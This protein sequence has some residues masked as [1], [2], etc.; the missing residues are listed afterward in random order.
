MNRRRSILFVVFLFLALPL[1]AFQPSSTSP[2]TFSGTFFCSSCETF[3]HEKVGDG[4]HHDSGCNQSG[5]PL[6]YCDCPIGY[7]PS[8]MLQQPIL[9]V[10]DDHT[11]ELEY[12]A[13][14][15]Y[16]NPPA[17]GGDI[18]EPNAIPFFINV[19]EIDPITLATNSTPKHVV[20]PYW[21]HGKVQMTD[22]N[23]GCKMY[24]AVYLVM[25]TFS[26]IYAVSSDVVGGNG[27]SS[28]SAIPDMGPCPTCSGGSGPSGGA[29]PGVGGPI[30]VGSGNMYY[31]EP[32]FRVDEP[33]SSLDF[34]I[35]YNSLETNAGAL[36]PGFT[37]SF[38]TSMKSTTGS[39]A[40]RVWRRPDGTRVLFARENHPPIGE[41][42][43]PIYP[44]DA[45]GYVIHDSSAGRYK[46]TEL[47]GTVTEVDDGSAGL[48][49]KTTDRWG[50]TLTGSYT[51]SNLTTITDTLG[52]T[53][54]LGYSGSLLTSITDG[55][56]N[57]WRFSYDGSS[58]LEKIFDPLHTS[59]T[60]WQQFTW[61]TY[62]TGKSAVA[63]VADD[64]GAVLEG[65]QYDTS[66]RAASSWSGDTTSGSAPS[67]GTNARDLVTLSYDSLTQTTV[68]TKID[69]SLTQDSVFTL[70]V[71]H[72]RFL[73]T[74][75]VGSC[76]SCGAT[77]DAQAFTFDDDNHV[78]TKTVGLDKTGSGGTDERV[79]SSFTYDANGNVLTAT[80]AVGKTEEHT[81]T[82][83]YGQANWPS[84]VT[85]ITETSVAKSG[86]SRTTT[87]AWNSGETQ[88][89]TT[90]SGYLH[91][92]DS[93]AT[94]YV[95]TSIFDSKHRLT[96]VD[97]PRTNQKTT[98][99]YYS[100]TDTTLNRRGRLHE[101][102]SYSTTSAFLTTSFDNYDVY[103]TAAKVTDPNS[104]DT[105]RTFDAR[106]RT[107]T[108][109]S[110]KPSS[111]SNEPADYDTTK[112]FDS[113]DRL[114]SKT[115][116]LGNIVRYV[117]EDGTNRL[118]QT[119]RADSSGN[120][121]ERLLLTLN[122]IGRKT[123]EAAQQC[124]SPANPCSSWTTKRSDAFAYDAAGRLA[125]VTHPDSTSVAHTYDSRGNLVSARDERHTAAN[126]LFGFDFRD[127]L[128][129]TTQKRTIVSGTD[130]VTTY[131]YDDQN[132]LVKVTDPKAND[133]TFAFDDFGRMQ[134]QASPVS[135]TA[136]Y[137]Y[138]EAG[139]LTSTTDAN[140]AT[141]ARTFDLLNR[142]LTA[143]STRSSYA[144]E[145]ITWTYDDA[146]AGN[147][148]LGRVAT[149]DDPS[150]TT[151]YDYERRGLVR[152]EYNDTTPIGTT[153]TYDAEGNGTTLGI[154]QYTFDFAGRPI[155]AFSD[156]DDGSVTF[157]DS[158]KYLPFGPMT[159]LTYGNGAVKTFD[160]DSRYRPSENKLT[161]SS[162]VIADYVYDNDE[163]GNITEI[164]DAVSSG[165]NRD[166][167]YDDLN[168]LITA[169]TGTSL[170]G[171][172]SYSYDVA[173]NMTALTLG[174]SRSASF[175]YSG[176]TS[177]LSSVNSAS[178]SYDSAGNEDS[179]TM[180]ARNLVAFGE[181]HYVYDGR[182]VR[183]FEY[184]GPTETSLPYN[185]S[186]TYSNDLKLLSYVRN[187]P[188]K[189]YATS[190]IWLNNIPVAQWGDEGWFP[191]TILRY[192]FTDHLGTPILQM[193]DNDVVWQAEYEPF[194]S[195]FAM[196]AGGDEQILRFPGQELAYGDTQRTYNIFRWYRSDWSRYT[197]SD[198]LDSRIPGLTNG[199]RYALNNPQRWVDPTGLESTHTSDILTCIS[200]PANCVTNYKCKE[201][202]IRVS[203][204][205]F[206]YD[207]DGSP[208]N[209]YKHCY[210]NCCMAKQAGAAAAKDMSGAH[211]NYAGN[212]PCSREMDEWNNDMGSMVTGGDS[213]D[214]HCSNAPLQKASRCDCKYSPWGQGNWTP[215]RP[216]A[217][218]NCAW[219]NGH[220]V[221][222]GTGI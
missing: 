95:T 33:V 89:T 102:K 9:R 185:R 211:E 201:E 118:L 6:Y 54:T 206:G 81:T 46:W 122:T 120:E 209:A 90:R 158:V 83:A 183:V 43:R 130:V 68:T 169:N 41:Y 124:P 91:S 50:N 21:E 10:I 84:F 53:W 47:D 24:R 156:G 97:G 170:W 1:L 101:M 94:S 129:T 157:V 174:S 28:C 113:R 5:S 88:L 146:T 199:Y 93:S 73:A 11:V 74:S 134:S 142:A 82:Y 110:V 203:T 135:G 187:I 57:Q 131:V 214:Q 153:Y 171:S 103:G 208:Q 204:Q 20:P 119:I 133:T 141:T 56:S 77:E 36:G 155:S 2:Y 175:S 121:H 193:V 80:Q 202:A 15:A 22:M 198:P 85:S 69:T 55:A 205:K 44:G 181:A 100:D 138:D 127:R 132:N 4:F 147:Y 116:P 173:S 108:T 105:T 106:G 166:F 76:G 143:T 197:Q 160:Y 194:G 99:T 221:C 75:I 25:D 145:T 58:R 177:K 32:L 70:T 86:Q 16:C 35:A 189:T 98:Q 66:G 104:V 7:N 117:Y 8:Q 14:N 125:T 111:D 195:V 45:T 163:A 136:T 217:P 167:A 48:W 67:P 17:D 126:I 29:S 65:H 172:G 27:S 3:S 31:T 64:S 168:R 109:T 12:F 178:V 165:Y 13:R 61:T 112:A 79:T 115:S 78:L 144:T 213:C 42:W 92:S 176:T 26:N 40:V 191:T 107:L 38:A 34:N 148:G 152:N 190:I 220:Y 216:T 19:I 18:H 96:E 51:G 159:E 49:R 114:T 200:N 60:P 186:A 192:T 123:S 23:P 184:L 149:M 128:T 72:G 37:H 161:L 180:N 164:H 154:A 215:S 196:R 219:S 212:P 30:N 59:T 52:R 188:T 63:L 222:A 210:W 39:S 179:V 150:G 71:G 207:R 62:T 140:S 139:N 162:T 218:Q 182:G 87:F 137:T 151:T